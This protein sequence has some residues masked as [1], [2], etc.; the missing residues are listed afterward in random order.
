[1]LKDLMIDP[2]FRGVRLLILAFALL[3][4]STFFYK[5]IPFTCQLSILQNVLLPIIVVQQYILKMGWMPTG[6]RIRIGLKLG[7]IVGASIALFF[8]I[9]QN[10][11]YYFFEGRELAYSALGSDITRFTLQTLY[12]DLST[13]VFIL[14][15]LTILSLISGL[16]ASMFVTVVRPGK[17]I[18]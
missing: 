10:I 12:M 13:D 3:S 1:M 14:I 9:V 16:M 7:G 6:N 2:R 5:T 8:I 18:D 17:P 4:L 15:G 11:Q